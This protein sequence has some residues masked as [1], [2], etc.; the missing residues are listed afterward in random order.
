MKRY[1][2]NVKINS[3]LKLLPI[4]EAINDEI[5]KLINTDED[6]KFQLTMAIREAIINAIIHGNKRKI[7]K[8]VN[9][10]YLINNKMIKVSVSDEG[11]G[12]DYKRL[13]NP[14]LPE[15]ILKPYG[16]GIFFIKSY[17]DKV[18]FSFKPEKGLTITMIKYLNKE[19]KNGFQV[20]I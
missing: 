18:K 8:L 10:N 11:K 3:D 14:T 16:R 17:M 4:I 2:L 20:Q 9:I 12:F 13:P 7:N 19:E 5:I 15:N 1:E 6:K